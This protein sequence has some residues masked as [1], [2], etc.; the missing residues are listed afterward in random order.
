M[1]APL[2]RFERPDLDGTVFAMVWRPNYFGLVAHPAAKYDGVPF[3]DA[4]DIPLDGLPV[5]SERP[6]V[7]ATYA[8]AELAADEILARAVAQ[9]NERILAGVGA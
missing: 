1:K 8:E 6:K 5:W 2:A 9:A 7:P 4:R 3:T